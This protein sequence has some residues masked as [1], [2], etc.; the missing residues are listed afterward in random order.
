MSRQGSLRS[1][2]DVAESEGTRGEG[3]KMANVNALCSLV[4]LRI[5]MMMNGLVNI[6]AMN[7]PNRSC[8]LLR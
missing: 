2:K 6:F 8:F 5:K 4:D 3:D 7:N 1:H